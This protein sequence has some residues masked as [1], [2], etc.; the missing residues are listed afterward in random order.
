MN[1]YSQDLRDRVLAALKAGKKSQREIAETFGIGVSTAEKWWQ[2]W[3]ET[4]RAC[5]LPRRHGPRRT[6][7]ACDDFIRA[8]VEKQPDVTLS[9]LCARVAEVRGVWANASMMCRT[10]QVL[11]L[12]RK[13]RHSTTASGRRRG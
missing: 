10:L 13:K 9:E 3:R 4:G 5:A 6:L 7:A 1:P 12:T 11:G 8:E 2:R